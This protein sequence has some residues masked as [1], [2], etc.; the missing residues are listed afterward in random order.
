MTEHLNL[1]NDEKHT[2][3]GDKPFHTSTARS[4]KTEDLTVHEQRRLKILRGCPLITGCGSDFK[5]ITTIYIS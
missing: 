3:S 5:E 4:E 2:L 1:T